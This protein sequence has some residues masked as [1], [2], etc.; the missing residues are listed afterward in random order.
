MEQRIITIYCLIEEF[1]KGTLGKEEHALS[2]ISDSE[3][4]FLGYLA[5]SDFNG[6]YAKAHYYGMGMKWVNKIEY[7]RF[8]RRINQLEREIEHFFLF[9]SELFK[10]L[11][12]SQIYSVDSFPVEICQ[13]QREKRSKLWRDVSLKGYNASKKKYFYGFKVHMVVTT[14]QE[15][16]SCYISEGSMHDTI[17]SYK[18]LPTLPTNSIVIGD[19]GYISGKLEKFLAKFGIELY[20]LSSLFSF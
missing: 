5:V 3:V 6:N 10:K 7:S 16:I 18:F 2:E 9:L 11:N 14:N 4:L 12:G 19:K 20:S 17:A 1:L 13:I 8:T 15:P